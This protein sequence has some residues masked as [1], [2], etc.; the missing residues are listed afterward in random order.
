MCRSYFDSTGCGSAI[1]DIHDVSCISNA[2]RCPSISFDFVEERSLESTVAQ[3]GWRTSS[4]STGPRHK[5]NIKKQNKSQSDIIDNNIHNI[6]LFGVQTANN[7]ST[8]CSNLARG[9]LSLDSVFFC[10]QGHGELGRHRLYHG[11][12]GFQNHQPDWTQ[13]SEKCVRRSAKCS[14]LR[15]RN[16]LGGSVAVGCGLCNCDSEAC[17][18]SSAAG[19][20]MIRHIRIALY[21][22]KLD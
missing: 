3:V 7:G 18:S 12:V 5:K 21:I 2:F 6:Q 17:H 10:S 8:A 1:R 4:S 22:Y 20:S 9:T 11:G 19:P 13:C 15:S 16:N 14:K